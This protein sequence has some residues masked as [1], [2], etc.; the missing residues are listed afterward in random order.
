MRSY[1]V[2]E[3]H[4]GSVVSE[5][6]RYTLHTDR[7]KKIDRDPDTLNTVKCYHLV[8]SEALAFFYG[9]SALRYLKSHLLSESSFDL[10]FKF[11]TKITNNI[12]SHAQYLTF[13]SHTQ[14]V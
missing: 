4:N 9:K 14:R 8:I 5:I 2:K 11:K 3:N 10:I 6:L 1:T 13:I 7:Q 12:F